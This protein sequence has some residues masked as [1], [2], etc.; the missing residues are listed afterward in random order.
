MTPPLKLLVSAVADIEEPPIMNVLY[1][2]IG[3]YFVDIDYEPEG[4]IFL[5]ES[6]VESWFEK[7]EFPANIE[8]WWLWEYPEE[9]IDEEEI[10]IL[11]RLKSMLILS[12]FPDEQSA[13]PLFRW[14]SSTLVSL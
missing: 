1:L 9:D 4:I 6:L 14:V 7:W 11:L 2:L 12:I 3:I 10:G 13:F 5:R 8:R